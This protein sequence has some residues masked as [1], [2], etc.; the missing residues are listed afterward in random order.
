MKGS[1]LNDGRGNGLNQQAPVIHKHVYVHVPPPDEEDLRAQR[2][3]PTLPPQKHYKIIFI[4]AP[5]EDTSYRQAPVLPQNEEKTLVY[6]LVK[7]PD[8]DFEFS[9]PTIAPTNPSKPEV[10]YIRYKT[11]QEAVN[12]GEFGVSSVG[13]N[14]VVNQKNGQVNNGYGFTSLNQRNDVNRRFEPNGHQRTDNAANLRSAGYPLTGPG[15]GPTG[16]NQRNDFIPQ[17]NEAYPQTAPGVGPSN[18]GYPLTA[19]GIGP[20]Q[21]NEG[22]PH[23]PRGPNQGNEF[24]F[25]GQRNNGYVY[26]SPID[27]SG[28][29]EEKT[30][31]TDIISGGTISDA[32]LGATGQ[33]GTEI[34]TTVAPS[35]ETTGVN[36]PY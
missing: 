28:V 9:V 16:G 17:R 36:V 3:R 32:L 31:Q 10:Y 25:N 1:E 14:S 5:T 20:N 13:D 33:T 2:P 27:R 4:K 26:S 35:Y 22:F 24:G 23:T 12:N 7:K 8:E 18:Q 11:R 6:V 29:V 30:G 21:R 19:P 34:V 15:V